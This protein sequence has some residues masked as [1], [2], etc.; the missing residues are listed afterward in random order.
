MK[1]TKKIN[2][3]QYKRNGFLIIKNIFNK[4]EVKRFQNDIDFFLNKKLR[5][6]NSKVHLAGKKLIQF[7]IL[8][9]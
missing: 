3:T 9:I 2:I 4:A 8:K 7:I 5:E 1:L 6:K